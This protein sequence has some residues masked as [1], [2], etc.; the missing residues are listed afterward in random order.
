[1]PFVRINFRGVRSSPL[2][3]LSL[4]LSVVAIALVTVGINPQSAS[5]AVCAD[6]DNQAEAQRAA[7]TRDADGDGIYCEALP[8]PCSKGGGGGGG[9]GGSHKAKKKKKKKAKPTYTYNGTIVDV[10]DGDTIKVKLKSGGTTTVR[11][12]GIDTP[13]SVKPA[14]PVEC[15]ALEAKS[16]AI[17]WSFATLIDADLN[18]LF[19]SGTDGYE[20]K[21]V[22]DN[23]QSRYDS[24]G[25]LLAYVYDT[26]G[27]SLQRTL[28]RA[29]WADTYYFGGKSFRKAEPYERDLESARH[30]GL[31]VFGPCLGDFHS[32]Q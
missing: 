17:E 14:T 6:Y 28:L 13:E 20:V 10:V 26:S 11:L 24:H 21:L 3:I 5:A 1:V 23:T 19:E 25:R 4:G 2:P 12:V 22:T 27:D 30:N 16:A 15:G 29:G 9:G 18:G 31:G 32:A 7:D 8:C